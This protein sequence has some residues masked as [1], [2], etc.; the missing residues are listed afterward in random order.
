VVADA[1]ATWLAGKDGPPGMI[2]PA[3]ARTGQ[4][5]RPENIPGLV[6]EQVTVK[7]TCQR[8]PGPRGMVDGALVISELHMDG[9]TEDKT[10]APATASSRPVAAATSRRS[11]WPCR[12]TRPAASRRAS[13][14]S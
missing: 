14:P 1:H 5:Y 12:S 10:F 4:V 6:F 3:N 7:C 13:W 9:A 11:H 2:M 8:V